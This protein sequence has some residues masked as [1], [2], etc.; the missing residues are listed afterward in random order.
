MFLEALHDGATI[1]VPGFF[2]LALFLWRYAKMERR[3]V[4]L[5]VGFFCFSLAAVGLSYLFAAEGHPAVATFLWR[6]GI[7]GEGLCA[8]G[9]LG[10]AVFR[11]ALPACK[12]PSPRILQ[13]LAV[14]VAAVV[15]T[16]VWLRANR[17]DLT[18]FLATSAVVSA[19]V[20]FSLQDT[21]GN[22][23]GGVAVQLDRSIHVG[24]WIQVDDLQGRVAEIRW[25]S[26]AVETRNWETVVIPNSLLV[27]N[28]F[29]VLGRRHGAPVQWR[30]TLRFN[31]DFRY[32]PTQVIEAV[33]EAVRAAALPGVA[34]DPAPFGLMMDFKGSYAEYAVRYWLTDL[35]VDDSADSNVRVCVYSAL[36]RAG[37]PLSIP[38]QTVFLTEETAERE[39]RK[40]Q[41]ERE[42]RLEAVRNVGIFSTLHPDEL[43]RLA[44]RLTP[45]P[46]LAGEMMTRQG[47][48]ADWL[49]LIVDGL[50]DVI[51][52][53]GAGRS[54]DIA[55][56]GPGSFFGEM[57][58]M[59]GEPRAASVVARTDVTAYCL[60]KSA[61]EEILRSR[62]EVAEEVSAVLA[63][64]RL[65]LDTA[66]QGLDEETRAQRLST[67]RRD[68]LGKIR[69]FFRLED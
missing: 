41:R 59:T 22:L 67:A 24:D 3:A 21:L 27:K 8:I 48:E 9:L 51:V 18:S 33:E 36:R 38:A 10:T 2:L 16:L 32:S 11:V 13:D 52:E 63:Q 14:S 58:L 12:M 49:Y 20:A 23:L 65:E 64:R 45:T 1:A 44:E 39:A 60:C 47:S 28:R 29:L 26:T 6:A 35:S 30:R 62:P 55:D 61:F 17:V 37:I 25:R 69:R 43:E 19:V 66:L 54:A 56:L 53:N 46:F 15:W 5:R 50:A 68:L 31:V 34:R 40:R 57:G 42:A 4:W 7:L